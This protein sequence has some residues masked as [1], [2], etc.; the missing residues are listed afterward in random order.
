MPCRRPVVYPGVAF[1]VQTE[2]TVVDA[3]LVFFEKDAC[4]RRPGRLDLSEAFVNP[5][6]LGRVV[7]PIHHAV[8][9]VAA[10]AGESPAADDPATRIGG[11]SIDPDRLVVGEET[12]HAQDHLVGGVAWIEHQVPGDPRIPAVGVVRVGEFLVADQPVGV[13]VGI[14]RPAEREL[15]QVAEARRALSPGLCF[16]QCREE[17]SR[18]NGDDGDDNQQFDQ[19]EAPSLHV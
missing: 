11:A 12:P 15:L 7:P 1:R 19:G 16:R 13:V 10:V 2:V 8:H 14:H 3:V 4:Q 9:R 5:I 18:Q 6:G 17:H